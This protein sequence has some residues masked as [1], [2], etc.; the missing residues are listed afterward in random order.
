MEPEG[1]PIRVVAVVKRVLAELDAISNGS[2]DAIYLEDQIVSRFGWATDHPGWCGRHVKVLGFGNPRG[3]GS[4]GGQ[5]GSNR[6]EDVASGG[7]R[8]GSG[9]PG[10]RELREAPEGEGE[11]DCRLHLV[12]DAGGE[13]DTGVG[14]H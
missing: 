5:I 8:A 14:C 11:A 7:R 9:V 3:D 10:K 2:T 4:L 13:D 1:N 6:G 12:G